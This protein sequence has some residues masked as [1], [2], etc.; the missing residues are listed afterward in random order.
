MSKERI[1]FEKRFALWH[2]HAGRCAYCGVPVRLL[3]MQVDHIL[4][5]WL[6]HDAQRLSR[7]KTDYGLDDSFDL[8]DYCNWLPS[9]AGCN[10]CKG[11]TLPDRNFALFFISLARGKLAQA[12]AEEQR[13]TQSRTADRLL[14]KLLSAIDIG[15]LTKQQVF[16]ALASLPE[17]VRITFD[18]IVVCFGVLVE[19]LLERADLPAN[20]PTDYPSL[21][22]WLEADL[23]WRVRSAFGPSS[24]YSESSSRN[25]ETLS[26]R[27]AL[28]DPDLNVLRGT[29]WAWW[30]I[31][32]VES[33]STLYGMTE[34]SSL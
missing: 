25:G 1:G 21:C 27:L 34:P 28:I 13:Y 11:E 30:E 14:G 24:S 8:R 31:L 10:R 29:D 12:R 4:P 23:L 19:E 33:Y 2:A 18:P 6:V 16:D 9:H 22:D 3:D 15:V 20:V 5:E 17:P 32:E 7:V 26:V